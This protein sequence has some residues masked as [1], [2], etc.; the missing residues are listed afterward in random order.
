MM[1]NRA[2]YESL[3]ANYEGC[4][5]TYQDGSVWAMVYL[6]N[7]TVKG[8]NKHQIAGALSVLEKQGHYKPTADKYFG[9]VRIK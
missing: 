5:S 4:Q 7:I 9:E 3:M 2:V 1:I 8:A 6:P